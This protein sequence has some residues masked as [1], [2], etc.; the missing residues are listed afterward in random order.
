M[1]A[2]AVPSP[3]STARKALL[4]ASAIL[5]GSKSTTAPLRRITVK[6]GRDRS[7]CGRSMGDAPE[8]SDRAHRTSAHTAVSQSRCD[9]QSSDGQKKWNG[10]YPRQGHP[11]PVAVKENGQH[12]RSPGFRVII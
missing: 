9:Q 5:A 6:G 10:P 7:N 1:R 4:I 2:D 12:G 11:A 8:I 3:P